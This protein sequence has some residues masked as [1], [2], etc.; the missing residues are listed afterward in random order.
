MSHDLYLCRVQ[1]PTNTMW[2]NF[3]PSSLPASPVFVEMNWSSVG[4]LSPERIN[5]GPHEVSRVGSILGVYLLQE[6]YI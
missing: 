4:V 1:G 3:H 2:Q 5:F 6:I